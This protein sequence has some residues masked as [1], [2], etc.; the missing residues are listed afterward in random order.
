MAGFAETLGIA[1]PI[2]ETNALRRDASGGCVFLRADNL[3][4]VH[5]EF[6]ADAKP[7][8]CSQYPV[9]A[10]RTESGVRIG[11]DPGCY[12]HA[13]SWKTAPEVQT[14]PLQA[15]VIEAPPPV[16]REEEAM[17]EIL[18]APGVSVP[19]ALRMLLRRPPGDA[20]PEP[21]ASRW[22]AHLQQSGLARSV[23][24]PTLGSSW[25]DA[26]LPLV[27]GLEVW[28]APP[29]WRLSAEADAFA[30]DAATRLVHLR[31]VR[32]LGSPAGATL[33]MLAG[34]VAIGWACAEDDAAFGRG[35]AGWSRLLRSPKFLAATMPSQE[36]LHQLVGVT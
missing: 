13:E 7:A 29:V 11:L 16:V 12:A 4:A 10:V 17:L 23:S 21:F 36:Q 35:I 1:E 34:A 24:D 6:G 14:G 3:C 28:D 5:A 26:L 30:I 9:V 18:G 22:L 2:V 25:R 33:M 32:R 31:L 8:I 27:R 15:S 19:G 20:L